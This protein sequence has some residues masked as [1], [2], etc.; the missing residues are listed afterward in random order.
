MVKKQV[1]EGRGVKVERK[2]GSRRQWAL[3]GA[4]GADEARQ[5]GASRVTVAR[6]LEVTARRVA[7]GAAGRASG[8]ASGVGTPL[9]RRG[10]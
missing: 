8:G 9:R 6:A 10:I 7:G 4:R 3:E 5:V 1:R 2:G